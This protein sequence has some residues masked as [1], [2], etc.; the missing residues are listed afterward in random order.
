MLVAINIKDKNMGMRILLRKLF[1]E[2]VKKF[3]KAGFM[4]E[5]L[6][7]TARGREALRALTM[8][9]FGDELIALADEQ[10]AEDKEDK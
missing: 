4:N 1:D 5:E 10:I 3:I 9:K 6:H 2:K 7:W 8:Q